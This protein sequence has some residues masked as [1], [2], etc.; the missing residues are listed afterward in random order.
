VKS[1][2][3]LKMVPARLNKSVFIWVETFDECQSSWHMHEPEYLQ[4]F[5]C[6]TNNNVE[7]WEAQ[8]LTVRWRQEKVNENMEFKFNFK[9]VRTESY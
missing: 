9:R 3:C 4:L 5:L 2:P 8:M 6:P 1:T 7:P